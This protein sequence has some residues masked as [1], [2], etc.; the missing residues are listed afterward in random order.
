[1]LNLKNIKK[2]RK[3][4]IDCKV[5]KVIAQR[6]SPRYY[7][8]E[9]I[10][11]ENLNIIFEAAR[12]TPS[13]YNLQPWFFYYTKKGSSSYS[14]LYSTLDTHNQSWAGTAPLLI[15]ACGIKIKN[16][17]NPY[18][19]YD[20]G[21]SVMNLTLQAQN[22]GYYSRQIGLFDKEK[23]KEIFQLEEKLQPFIIIALGKIG[24]YEMCSKEI[25]KMEI[26]PRP[27]KTDIVKKL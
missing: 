13:A 12:W 14:K 6:W 7:S 3:P 19:Y 17:E 1:M 23:V 24:D 2:I 9:S 21:A 8:N 20:L 10:S 22:L 27:R 25:I 11:E 5:M 15:L 26:S 4:K 16:N 18:L